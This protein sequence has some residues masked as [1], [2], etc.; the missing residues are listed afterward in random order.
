[1]GG[2]KSIYS[3]SICANL[4]LN[5]HDL[6]NEGGEGNQTLPRYVTILDA[7]GNPV[8]VTAVSGD[9]LKH[10]QSEYLWKLSREEK[11]ELCNNC[12]L[13][14]PNRIAS[15][16]NFIQEQNKSKSK[17]V[18]DNLIKTC[19]IDDLNGILIT[20]LGNISR[21]SVVEFGWLIGMPNRNFSENYIHTKLVEDAA[22]KKSQSIGADDEAK[23]L[24]RSNE[25]QNIFYRPANSGNYALV[26]NLD[27]FRIGFNDISKSYPDSTIRQ[28]RFEVLLKS[29]MF[30]LTNIKGAMR[31]TQNP[32]NTKMSG[33]ITIS[34]NAYPAP[35]I[36]PLE[37]DYIEQIEKIATSLNESA[38]NAIEVLKF[39]NQV[40]FV[41]N[42]STIIS[43]FVPYEIR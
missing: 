12:K 27:V 30:T 37:N 4:E 22:L 23:K 10:I 9:M 15:D 7:E 3:L 11:L 33:V 28:K 8:K 21:K 2:E 29:I 40:E 32:H 24:K 43:S 38:S 36:S 26:L 6:N 34:H 5:L 17:E 31:N 14:N 25:G 16:T 35:Q 20:D 13:F 18:I 41:K 42:M 1:M 19:T 39:S